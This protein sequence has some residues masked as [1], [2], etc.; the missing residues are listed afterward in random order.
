MT[1]GDLVGAAGVR[2]EH[3]DD[4]ALDQRGVDVHHDQPHAA[5]EQVR[6]LDGDVD[7]LAGGLLDQRRPQP[8][9]VGAGDVQVDRGDRVARHP[10]D[11][12]DVGARV[13]D[14]AGDRGHRRRLER[15]ADHA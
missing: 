9:G 4:L 8:V 6:G 12:V 5:A 2:G 3:L 15:G 14:P 11:P 13:G 10:L 1:R 7:A